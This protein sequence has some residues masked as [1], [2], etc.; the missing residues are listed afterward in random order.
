M[1]KWICLALALALV[2]TCGA[3]SNDQEIK[4]TFFQ[5]G[6]A[7]AAVIQTKN[8]VI[9]VDTG[10]KKNGKELVQALED[11]GVTKIDALIISHFDKDHVGGAA[12]ILNA[13][14]VGSVYQSNYP[15]NSEEYTAYVQA[16]SDCGLRAQTVSETI[17]W[18]LDGV[19]VT[20]DGPAEAVY[21]TDPSNNSS[22]IVS[23]TYGENTILFAGDAEDSRIEE[24]LQTYQRQ[25]GKL[26]LKVPYH[27]HW[28]DRLPD[29]LAAAVPDAAIIPCSK[30]EPEAEELDRT[31]SLLESLGAEVY[32]TRNGDITLT[33]TTDSYRLAQ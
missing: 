17:S 2:W 12:A 21:D 15:K 24:F 14:E 16:L 22:L 13:F 20:I 28:Q 1:K 18:T 30:S 3:C 10:L 27:G 29:L 26:I 19:S 32:L 9:V 8:A 7:D 25:E 33:C 23:V 4:V 31:V 5:A 11:L 6:K